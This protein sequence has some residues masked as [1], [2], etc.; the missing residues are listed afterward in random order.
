[1][2]IT[3]KVTN[4]L[5]STGGKKNP[6]AIAPGSDP[7]RHIS[8]YQPTRVIEVIFENDSDT[9]LLFT[10]NEGWQIR[11]RIHNAS[12]RIEPSLKFDVNLVSSPH[13]L[14]TNHIS[15]SEI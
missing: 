5:T 14:F 4:Y 10:L 8:H 15:V 3:S 6:V 7:L 1:M 12:S 11:F 2:L 13:T 9:S